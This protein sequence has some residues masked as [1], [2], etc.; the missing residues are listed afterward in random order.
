MRTSSD[1]L[2]KDLP[3]LR[4]GNTVR[5]H[6]K[7]EEGGKTRIQV[8]EGMVIAIKH[9]RGINSTF[10]V[11]KKI[12][13]IGVERVFPLHSPNIEKIELVERKRTRR[14]K[15]YYLRRVVGKKGRLKRKKEV[16]KE[17]GKPG[18]VI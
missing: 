6:Q 4:S 9:G 13:D 5:V 7:L 3:A 8:F 14:A 11:R 1:Q 16:T 18:E 2:K 15:L 10:T 12:G 17:E